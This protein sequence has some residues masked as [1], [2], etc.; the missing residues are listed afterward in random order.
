MGTSSSYQAPSD[1]KWPAFKNVATRFARGEGATSAH[2]VL[3]SFVAALGGA[4]SAAETSTSGLNVAARL[5]Q[6]VT[7]VGRVGLVAALER[8]D[9]SELVG[10]PPFEVLAALLERLTAPGN[11][12]EE[13]AARRALAD[14]EERMERECESFEDLQ[15][16]FSRYA[17][18]AE[19]L[20]LLHEY[21]SAYVYYRL[22]Q[23]LEARLRDNVRSDDELLT[24]E[25]QL[26]AYIR[27]EMEWELRDIDP[28]AI[29]WAGTEGHAI[30]EEVLQRAYE[31]AGES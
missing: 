31:V 2:R 10:R 12:Q 5:T 24:L 20:S 18:A 11:T 9:L 8:A 14:I 27:T 16:L 3:Q 1:G 21:L 6:F 30:L 28:F 7:G 15:D 17:D 19:I 13:S 22:L 25:Q 26:R 4:R 23:A 29:D